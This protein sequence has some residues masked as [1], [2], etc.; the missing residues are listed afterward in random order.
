MSKKAVELI[1]IWKI[2][3][4]KCAD[5]CVYVFEY[6]PLLSS[7]NINNEKGGCNQLLFFPF[8]HTFSS[9]WINKLLLD[10]EFDDDSI[11]WEEGER[12]TWQ[13]GV[14]RMRRI[15]K[16]V[17]LL[18][19]ATDQ[20]FHHHPLLSLSFN[21]LNFFSSAFL[22][23][24]RGDENAGNIIGGL[25]ACSFVCNYYDVKSVD[26]QVASIF[27]NWT[28]QLWK[29]KDTQVEYLRVWWFTK[30]YGIN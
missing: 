17:P 14:T 24:I 25:R 9:L 2:Q 15:M 4:F 19:Q 27:Q 28:D 1:W 16:E 30:K 29:Q 26:C 3:F 6:L 22:F 7:S 20:T 13:D 11:R 8:L 5:D 21:P 12:E 10:E 23:N 18:V